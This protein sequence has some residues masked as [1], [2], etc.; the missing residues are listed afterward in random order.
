MHYSRRSGFDVQRGDI[1][2]GKFEGV[3]QS[4]EEVKILYS[5][6]IRHAASRIDCIWFSEDFKYIPAVIEIEHSTGVTSGVTRMLKLWETIP[7]IT[8]NFTVVAP[9]DLRNKVVSEANNPAF[10]TL[11]TRY[12]PYS[13]VRILYGL[14]QRYDLSNVVERTFIEPFLENIVE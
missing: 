7:S 11:N 3:V 14:I 2:L 6:E 1:E 10:I 12:M 9:D 5:T 8:A 4:L 13:T